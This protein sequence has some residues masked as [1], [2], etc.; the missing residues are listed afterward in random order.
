MPRKR[1]VAEEIINK[2]REGE[3]RLARGET[4]AL[5]CKQLG[6]TGQTLELS[7]RAGSSIVGGGSTGAC[8]SIKR[9]G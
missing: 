2:L 1:F 9:G 3:V 8:A 5:A 4:V 6:V 7:L